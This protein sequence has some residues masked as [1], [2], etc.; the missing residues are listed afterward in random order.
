MKSASWRSVSASTSSGS[1][2]SAQA[3]FVAGDHQP[4]HLVAQLVVDLGAAGSASVEQPP[5][6]GL[7]VERGLA[8]RSRR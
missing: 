4:P 1:S 7:D 6:L 2:P 8:A 5:D 3:P